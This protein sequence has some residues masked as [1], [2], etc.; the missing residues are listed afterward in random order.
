MHV[1]PLYTADW[2]RNHVTTCVQ[3]EIIISGLFYTVCT[4][5]RSTVRLWPTS[6]AILEALAQ[7]E[8]R[9][10]QHLV[11]NIDISVPS[12][13]FGVCNTGHFCSSCRLATP[14]PRIC[15]LRAPMQKIRSSF[16]DENQNTTATRPRHDDVYDMIFAGYDYSG[17]RSRSQTQTKVNIH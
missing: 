3:C 13:V 4:H 7:T 10:I 1:G 14:M 17:S 15:P 12:R 6:A 2:C 8:G 5:T 9:R 16:W 11:K